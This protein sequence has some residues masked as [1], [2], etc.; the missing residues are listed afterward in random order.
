MWIVIGIIVLAILLSGVYLA[1][2]DGNY[3]VKRERV[4]QAPLQ[5]V[6]AA[7][8]DFKSWPHWSP[9][10]M[11]EADAKIEYSENYQQEGGYYTWEGKIV[12]AGRLTHLGINPG[13]SINQQ[14]EFTRPF[15]SVNQVNWR[16]E[17]N[18]EG[19]RVSWEMVG[20][21][22]FFFRFMARQMEP[23]IGRDYELG[24]A[25]LN[26]YLN[27]NAPHP[28]ISFIGSET[29][30]DFSY[31]AIPLNGNLRQL[32][33][34]RKNDIAILEAAAGGK[35]GL[36][37]TIYH[38]LDSLQSLYNA[39]IAIPVSENMPR[40]NYTRRVFKGGRYFK[41]T[42]HGDHEFLPLAWHALTS[43]C[44]MHK[45]KLDKKRPSIEIYHDDPA[46]CEHSNQVSTVLYIAIK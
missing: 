15:K 30:D 46:E 29:L 21:M 17:S 42:L 5:D 32:E 16:V 27:D 25:L 26:G 10:L 39:E 1:S 23:M 22:P 33:T 13:R 6:F 38:Q 35:S 45:F 34:A 3:R 43:H 24:L 28:K 37:L 4:I 31:W 2:L 11:H 20:S 7:I 41:M 9:W 18:E 36:A 8:I 12:G 44:R 19:T 14:I 40:S